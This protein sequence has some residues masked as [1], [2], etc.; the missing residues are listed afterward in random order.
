MHDLLLQQGFDL[1]LYGMGTVL[2]FLTI[3]VITTALMS[4]VMQR[5]FPD[6]ELPSPVDREPAASAPAVSR[7][8]ASGPV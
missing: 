2:T 1:M 6:P 8:C 7:A 5:F 3:L 4:A